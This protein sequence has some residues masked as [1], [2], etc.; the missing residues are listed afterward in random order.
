MDF[1]DFDSFQG[2]D[3]LPEPQPALSLP[4]SSNIENIGKRI[5]SFN[6]L[7]KNLLKFDDDNSKDD[8]VS[9]E[10]KLAQKYADMSLELI[11]SGAKNEDLPKKKEEL[12]PTDETPSDSINLQLESSTKTLSTRLARVLNTP[13]S[14]NTIR[15]IFAFLELKVDNIDNLVEPGVVGSVSRKQFRGTIEG[16]LIQ[17]QSHILKEYQPVIKQLKAL[18]DK[19]KAV[20]NYLKHATE[21]IEE[22]ETAMNSFH[23]KVKKSQREK[24]AIELKKSL[25]TSFKKKFTLNEYEE[26]VLNEGEINDEF[27]QTLIKAE[28]ISEDCSILLSLNNPQLGLKIMNRINTLINKAIDRIITFSNKTLSNLYALN[29]KSK[30]D[31]LHICLKYLK[32]KLNYFSSI[33][34]TF[35]ESRSKV[36]VDE[37]LTQVGS[38][39]MRESDSGKRLSVSTDQSSRPVM[40]SAHDPVR[41]IGDLLAYV[42]SVVLNENEL[43]ASIFTFEAATDDEKKEFEGISKEITTKAVTALSKPMKSKIDQVLSTESKLATIFQIFN[44]LDLYDLMFSKQLTENEG[45]LLKS[46]KDLIR[47]SQDKITTI[48]NNRLATIRTSNLAQLELSTDL[49]PPEWI[50]EFYF[51]LLPLIDQTTT[52]TI[53][54]LPKEENNK[55]LHLIVNRPI[56]IFDEH[57]QGKVAKLFSKRDQLILKQNFLDLVLSKIMPITLLN[58]KTLEINELVHG[59]TL[60][61]TA[62]QLD[63][64]LQEC[65]MF[66]FYNIINMIYPLDNDF[67]DTSIYQPITENKLFTKE[68]VAAANDKSQQFLPSALLDVQQTLLK[69]NSPLIVNDII[70]NSSIQF[71]T[72]YLKF[73]LICKQYLK[74][75]VLAW[76]DYEVAT[77]LGVEEQYLEVKQSM[78][79]D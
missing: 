18:E 10:T 8:V 79:F 53:L 74:E 5:T 60:E 48:I 17:S 13:L 2:E 46:I 14:D 26:F 9:E 20:N 27:F 45:T 39:K 59:L 19:L 33:I 44:T 69:I 71:V 6:S 78:K 65:Q 52:T 36:I 47:L 23:D 15:E 64:L 58:E 11:N 24:T 40:L 67:F 57:I 21:K 7:T 43:I 1:I 29:T 75:S 25:L 51:D 42:H 63:S 12:L 22:D 62:V 72:F 61:L 30:L 54:N 77:L 70:T 56:E 38:N 34:N 35:A 73:N 37:F 49:Q 66:D 28:S 3:Q 68:T 16:D 32:N 76:T 55:L 31:T 4:I 41:F 50:I